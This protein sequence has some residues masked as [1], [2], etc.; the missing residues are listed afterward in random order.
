MSLIILQCLHISSHSVR[1]TGSQSQL[2]YM[3]LQHSKPSNKVQISY[4]T[5]FFLIRMSINSK[6]NLHVNFLKSYIK[7]SDQE[8]RAK[9]LYGNHI[10]LSFVLAYIH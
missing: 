2:I 5:M 3:T 4:N 7:V 9:N 10:N 1:I 6:T 8:A